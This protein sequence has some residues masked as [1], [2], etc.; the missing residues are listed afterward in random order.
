M[1]IDLCKTMEHVQI[2]DDQAILAT[3]FGDTLESISVSLDALSPQQ[4]EVV[5]LAY[6]S[7]LTH[8]NPLAHVVGDPAAWRDTNLASTEALAPTGGPGGIVFGSDGSV[9]YTAIF[10]NQVSRVRVK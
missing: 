1:A 2:A 3:Q 10:A 7:A 9:W 4:R 5:E 6:R 8:P